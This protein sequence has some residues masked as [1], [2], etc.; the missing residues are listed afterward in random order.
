M[1]S[2]IESDLVAT[3]T[4]R[5]H[6]MKNWTTLNLV[7]GC[8]FVVVPTHWRK[9]AHMAISDIHHSVWFKL[10]RKRHKCS[11]LHLLARKDQSLLLWR[12][13]FLFFDT[14]L[15]AIDFVCGLNVDFD[16]FTS[17]C[18]W[19]NVT[20]KWFRL[21]VRKKWRYQQSA[22]IRTKCTAM[23]WWVFTFSLLQKLK[24]IQWDEKDFRL[25][26]TLISILA[27]Q[28]FYFEVINKRKR[29]TF[30]ENFRIKSCCFTTERNVCVSECKWNATVSFDS[31]A[32]GLSTICIA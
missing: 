31:W 2:T 9:N 32:H 6:Q 14:L 7:V 11:Y 23:M 25:T 20:C 22:F 13:A 10:P 24:P 19:K 18:L 28:L 4:K 30:V 15:N 12:D 5:Q 29:F 8:C 26:L 27:M 21:K 1:I 3:T 17:Q 16:F